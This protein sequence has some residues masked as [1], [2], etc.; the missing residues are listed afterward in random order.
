MYGLRTMDG[1]ETA[2]QPGYAPSV[3]KDLRNTMI[4]CILSLLLFILAFYISDPVVMQA[5]PGGPFTS[6]VMG[7]LIIVAVFVLCYW[8][9]P[10]KR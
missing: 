6:M 3:K 7:I 1:E 10:K 4:Y 5:L 8:Q 9:R 2:T